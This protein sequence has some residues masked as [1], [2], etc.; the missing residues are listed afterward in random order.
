[1]SGERLAF[2]SA[3]TVSL[4]DLHQPALENGQCIALG[5]LQDKAVSQGL[6]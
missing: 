5:S 1:M 6:Y 3:Q 4:V 2:R